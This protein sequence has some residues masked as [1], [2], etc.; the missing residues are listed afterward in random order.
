MAKRINQNYSF[1]HNS[2]G[3]LINISTAQRN[4][5][6]LCPICGETMTPHMGRIRRWH[7][8]HK[9]TK[10]CSYES[11]LHML[12]KIRIRDAFFSSKCLLL[13]YEASAECSYDCPFIDS[14]KCTGKKRVTFNLK[15][16]YDNCELEA[17]YK[18]FRADLLLSSSKNSKL[19]P[20]LIEIKVTHK[21]T[22]EKIN[23][24]ARIIEIPISSEEDIDNIINN[25]VLNAVR[26]SSP[27]YHRFIN[28]KDKVI[29][30]YNFNKKEKFSPIEYL[31]DYEECGLKNT[32]IFFLNKQ[33]YFQ[34]IKCNCYEVKQM[35]DTNAHY[36]ISN[37]DVSYREILH[38]FS[39]RGVKIRNCFICKYSKYDYWNNRICVLY[40]TFNLPRKPSPYNAISC[41]YFREDSEIN[42][43]TDECSIQIPTV[44]SLNK[45]FYYI[46]KE[47]L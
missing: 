15:D 45:S 28:P 2:S 21:C 14:P 35:T 7:F 10:D 25:A 41:S 19:P 34:S 39:K 1:A 4:E 16:Y 20:T 32:F 47:I 24:G 27:I 46:C 9:N 40:K 36:F 29:I 31:R 5:K 12:A 22:D 43:T 44:S 38:G 42:N 37:I 23:D 13:S 3:E 30:L 6:Y 18:Q 8:V 17:P 11:Y 33:G 26:Y